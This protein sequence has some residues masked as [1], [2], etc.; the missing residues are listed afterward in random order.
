MNGSSTF[1]FPTEKTAGEIP[2]LDFSGENGRNKSLP[3]LLAG[4]KRRKG[5]NRAKIVS[6]VI[7]LFVSVLFAFPFVYMLGTS[8]KTETDLI[9]NP[10]GIFP[11]K[12]EWTL[13]NYAGFIIRDGQLDNVPKWMF[14][15]FVTC[16]L[17][18]VITLTICTLVAYAFV[19]LKF[20]GRKTLY[21]LLIMTL[22]VPGVIGTTA[23]YSM[24]A[25]IGVLTNLINNPVYI[26]FWIIVPGTC[27]VFNVYLLKNSMDSIPMEI[28]ESAHSDGASNFRIYFRIVMPLIRSTLILI[29]LFCF[30]GSWNAL[31]WPQ[32][33]LSG[34]GEQGYL[35]ITVALMGYTN[36]VDGW[37]AKAVAMAT[38]AFSLIPI[39]IIFVFAQKRMIEGMATTGIKR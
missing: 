24:Y 27:G 36:Q 11:S 10:L 18:I 37:N 22:T 38:S 31:L 1:L 32:L 20:R 6:F 33:L 30:T 2:A 19:F 35:T 28:V 39:L 9:L 12:G 5:F 29:G 8:F 25:N 23:Q 14:N 21:F 16:I 15:S 34:T 3:L 7:L 17:N 4:T 13:S 26:Y